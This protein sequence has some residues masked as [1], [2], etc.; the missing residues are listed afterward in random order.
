MEP[1]ERLKIERLVAGGYSLAR[2]SDGKVVFL[3]EG[4]PGE[5]VIASS[6]KGKQDFQI[7]KVSHIISP[8]EHRRERLCEN[9]PKCGGCDR[10]DLEYS[11]Q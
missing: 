7:M 6:V 9:F 11:R 2:R 8:S 1:T 3:Q 4:Y 10:Q 5:T